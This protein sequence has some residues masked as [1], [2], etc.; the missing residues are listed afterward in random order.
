MLRAAFIVVFGV[1]GF[2][3][4]REAYFTCSRCTSRAKACSWRFSSCR[5]SPARSSV[6]CSRRSRKRL[7]EVRARRQAERAMERLSPAEIAGGAV[8][9]DRRTARRVSHQ[10]H[11]L[12]GR[13]PDFGRAGTYVAIVLYL[14]VAIFAAYL[15]ARVGAKIRIVPVPRR[16]PRA[17]AAKASQDRRHV[18]DRGRTDRRNRGERVPRGRADRAALRP[19]RAAGDLRLGGPAQAH[20]RAARLRRAQPFA[21]AGDG[22]NQRARLRRHGAGKR[23]RAARAPGAR[24]GCEARHQR[25]QPQPRRASRGRR[26]CSTSTNWRTRS[27]RSCFRARSCTWR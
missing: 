10:E 27:S 6:R 11:H 4:G 12:R 24:A 15:G 21:G 23:R 3:L 20:A 25:L 13:S 26:R 1:T 22:R 5:R 7:F 16:N 8:G 18:V 14:I 9:L 2:L 19:A 17:G